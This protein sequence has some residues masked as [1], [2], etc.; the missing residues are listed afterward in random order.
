MPPNTSLLIKS[1]GG[2]GLGDSIR[3]LLSGLHYATVSGR[4]LAVA[5]DDGL[6]GER[7]V[8]VFPELLRLVGFDIAP[9]AELNNQSVCP[10]SWRGALH[11]SLGEVYARERE[12]DWNRSWALH[13]LSFD[14]QCFDYAEQVLV[15]WDFD[16]FP[17]SWV[18]VKPEHKIGTTPDA[19]LR[20]LAARHLRPSER[21]LA[22]IQRVRSHFSSRMVG[23]HIRKTFELGGETRHIELG[24]VFAVVDRLLRRGGAKG[25][26]LATDNSE[27]ESAFLERYPETQTSG[28]RFG[29]PG[30]ALHFDTTLADR[31][32]GA[33]EALV[34]LYL[35]AGCDFLIYPASSSFSRVATILGDIP[36]PQ[37]FPLPLGRPW[38]R[39]AAEWR[40]YRLARMAPLRAET[41]N[42][43]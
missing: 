29:L 31:T 20:I 16:Q 3:A 23:V 37:L 13:H 10:D 40:A 9:L 1:T 19:A 15:M 39:W 41:P 28:K 42:F 2:A 33:V 27:V 26:F 30:V 8:N 38:R 22:E 17:V 7:G 12:D 34:D 4:R 18:A 5:W 32:E 11:L 14:Q 21:V 43:L 24:E 6:Y 35:L 25:V 36:N